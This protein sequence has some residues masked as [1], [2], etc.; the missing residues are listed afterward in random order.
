MK[1]YFTKRDSPLKEKYQSLIKQESD[2]VLGLK[3]DKQ[4]NNCVMQ[5]GSETLKGKT[6]KNQ[7]KVN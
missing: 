4:H 7:D 1:Q 6:S 5:V 2:K 3:I